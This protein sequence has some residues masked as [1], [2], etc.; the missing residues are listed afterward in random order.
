MSSRLVYIPDDPEAAHRLSPHW[1]AAVEQHLERVETVLRWLADPGHPIH[2]VVAAW[3]ERH[4]GPATPLDH[5][6]LFTWVVSDRRAYGRLA[7]GETGAEAIV[8]DWMR[9]DHGIVS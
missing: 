8:R 6:T 1:R 2:R 5:E 3:A 7:R 4:G 9:A